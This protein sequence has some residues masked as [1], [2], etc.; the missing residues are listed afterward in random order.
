[1]NM[2]VERR[3]YRKV[4][5]RMHADEKFRELSKPKPNGQTLW[6][7]LITGP[8]TTSVPGLFTAGEA[9]MAEALD[10]PLAGFRR[11][12][13]E[14]ES[15]GMAQ[16]DWKARVV[17]LPNA[18]RH[19]PP[20]SPNV[21]R[22]W[23]AAIDEITECALKRRALDELQAFLEGC[24]SAFTKAFREAFDEQTHHPSPNQEQEQEQ[25]QEALR[26]GSGSPKAPLKATP[27]T[28]RHLVEDEIA[29][30]GAKLLERF[31][32]LYAEYRRGAHYRARPNLDWTDAC[33]LCRHWDDARLE[34]LVKVFLTTD[35]SWI[36]G[37]DRSF[38][39]FAI[40]AT[41]AD[42]RLRAAESHVA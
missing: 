20:E 12:W 16:A 39:I 14:I 35:D 18:V 42:D 23:R 22:G 29:E 27:A 11:A 30:R 9:G 31:G 21:V 8:H 7:Y 26:L 19:N 40:K 15:R 24:G 3:R 25:E 6:Q 17:W 4:L 5:T 10:W 33:D 37:T 36:A 2:A 13:G 41:W 28:A 34:K 32:V 1:M 38:K